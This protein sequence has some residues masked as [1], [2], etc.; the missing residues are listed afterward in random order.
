MPRIVKGKTNTTL[1]KGFTVQ[2]FT[3]ATPINN[4]D[5]PC[6]L[7]LSTREVKAVELL[8]YTI[9][10]QSH[11]FECNSRIIVLVTVQIALGYASCNFTVS[12]SYNYSRIALKCMQ[13]PIL[14]SLVVIYV[15]VVFYIF[16]LL[17]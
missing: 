15:T 7:Q 8:G 3:W 12:Y 13:L 9:S 5:L 14:I 6:Q 17:Y 11:I 2:V 4:N 1:L 16:Y 10:K